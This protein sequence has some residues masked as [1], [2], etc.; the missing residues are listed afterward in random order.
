MSIAQ[1]VFYSGQSN[2]EFKYLVKFETEF[3]NI[4]GNE[5]I[6]LADS[7]DEKNQKSKIVCY[8]SLK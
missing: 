6:F 5:S 1:N 7:F 4:T 8:Y 2:F 3:E